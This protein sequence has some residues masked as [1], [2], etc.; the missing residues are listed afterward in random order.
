MLGRRAEAGTVT[1]KSCSTIRFGLLRQ[2]SHNPN[3][4][5]LARSGLGPS[6]KWHQAFWLDFCFLW[7]SSLWGDIFILT[8]G[9]FILGP[10]Q[11]GQTTYK[12]ILPYWVA[13]VLFLLCHLPAFVSFLRFRRSRGF[14]AYG[15]LIGSAMGM[16]FLIWL[17]LSVLPK[18]LGW[19]YSS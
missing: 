5:L 7:L 3:R 17:W 4:K 15:L 16:A 6:Q 2:T 19:G 12:P 18:A 14:F 11:P 10:S 9:T 1:G 13:D 8:I